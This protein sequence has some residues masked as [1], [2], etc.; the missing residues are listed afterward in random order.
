MPA[1]APAPNYSCLLPPSFTGLTD[2]EDILTQF[3]AASMLSN[4]IALTPDPRQHFFSVRRSGDA[5]TFS[6][7]LT[8][9]QKRDYHELNRLFRQQYKPNADVSKAQVKSLRHLPGQGLSAFYRTLRDLAGKASIDDAVRNELL[10]STFIERLANFVVRWEVRKAKPTV[11]ED[12]LSLALEMQFHLNLHGQKSETPTASVNNLPGPSPSQSEL[13][14]DLIFTIKEKVKRVLDEQ[15][16]SPQQGRSGERPT[17]NRSQQLESNNDTSQ[18]QRRTWNQKKRNCP[19]SRG[20]TRNRGRSHDSKKRVSFNNS[21]TK[22]AKECPRCHCQNHETNDCKTCFKCGR[23]GH[24]WRDCRSR[25][26][27]LN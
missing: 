17:I 23:V 16:G 11:V 15:S 1:P 13:F 22:S 9:A 24:F 19:N 7:S 27:L 21:G 3:E 5:L 14:S 2:V 18:H 20:N 25:S 26:Q 8:T 10:L 6:R 12:A 4:W